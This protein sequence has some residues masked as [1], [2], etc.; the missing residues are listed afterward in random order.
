MIVNP[1]QQ[2]RKSKV[3]PQRTGTVVSCA[4]VAMRRQ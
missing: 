3:V 4:A 1:G 2:S